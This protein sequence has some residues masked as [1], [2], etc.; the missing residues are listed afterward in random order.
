MIAVATTTNSLLKVVY[1]SLLASIGVAVVFS[2]VIYGA[3]RSS[4]MRRA[5]RGTA[6]AAFAALATCGFLAF[7]GLVVYGVILVGHKG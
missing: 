4:E 1:S 6:A 7:A 2:L 3:I 5:N